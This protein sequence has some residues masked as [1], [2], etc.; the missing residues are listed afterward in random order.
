MQGQNRNDAQTTEW[1]STAERFFSN[2]AIAL[3]STP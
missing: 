3:G 1:T 2:E